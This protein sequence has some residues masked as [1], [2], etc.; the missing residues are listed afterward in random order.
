MNVMISLVGEQPVPNLL[1]LRYDEPQEAVL[2]FTDRT[3]KVARRLL[4]LLEKEIKIYLLHADPYE[5]QKIRRDL[6]ELVSE[7]GWNGEDLA[8]NLTG[9]TKTMV[10]AAYQIAQE[11]QAPF[12]YLQSEGKHSRLYRYRLEA[13]EFFKEAKEFLP[14]I[15]NI[16]DYLQAHLGSLPQDRVRPREDF[17]A[18]F[19][20]AIAVALE[21][22]G[23]EVR[24]GVHLAGA[25]E[26][27]LVVRWENQVGVIQAKTGGK[28][29]GKTGLDQLNAVCDQR[30]LGTYTGKIL[31]INMTWDESQSNLCELAKAWQT[32]VIELPSFTETSPCLSPDDRQRLQ[33]NVFKVLRGA[34]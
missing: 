3:K 23:L 13:R 19:E 32:T 21:E 31:V 8:F 27:D 14:G 18:A 1:V 11:F 24:V 16:D 5:V 26:V 10:L 25:L 12:F 22:I 33:E 17:G 6:K 2:V 29:R 20:E 15:I 4:K 28:A 7:Q 34:A 30:Y 9:G